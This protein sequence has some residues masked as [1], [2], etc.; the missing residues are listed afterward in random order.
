MAHLEWVDGDVRIS[1]PPHMLQK[2][3]IR[4]CEADVGQQLT[5]FVRA[6]AE[7]EQEAHNPTPKHLEGK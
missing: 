5:E 2:A 3:W 6:V 7:V 4:W 1:I